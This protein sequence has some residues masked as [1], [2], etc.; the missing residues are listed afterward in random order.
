MS[1]RMTRRTFLKVTA[2]AGAGV[3]FAPAG[4]ARTYE[5]NERVNVAFVGAGGMGGGNLGEISRLQTAK[6]A[7]LANVVALCDVDRN[8]LAGAAKN[9]PAAKTYVDFRKMLSEMQK[10]IDAVMVSTPDHT[11]YPA[12]AMAIKLGMGVSTEKPLTHSIWEAR[13]LGL[14]A[15]KHKVATQ[16]DHEGHAGEGLRR[17][18]E[19]IKAGLIGAVREAHIFTDRPIWPQGIAKRPPTEPVPKHLEWDLWIGPAPYRDYHRH[20]HPFAWRGWWDFGTGALG[21]MG[22]HFFD[23][24]FWALDLGEALKI[25]DKHPIEIS[26]EHEGNSD[27]TYPNWSIVTLK[28]P[29]RGKLPPVTVKWYDGHKLPTPPKEF[30]EG[31][32]FPIN[33]SMFIGDKGPMLVYDTGGARLLPESRM[34]EEEVR[35][36]KPF[37]PRSPGHK[38]E[39]LLA[40]K[41]EG[42]ASSNFTDYGGPLAEVVLLGN[43]AIKAGKTVE[44]D[45]VNLKA[46]NAPELAPWIHRE[47][48]KGWE[49]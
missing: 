48:R 12:S 9:H 20:L 34:K 41:G 25:S 6:G 49:V 10:G 42:K 19:Y 45:S 36:L 1:H 33:G 32:K 27:E 7:L 18:V 15:R 11:H 46:K 5:A 22:C 24:A 30:G 31:R 28:F 21:D 14:L 35:N 37:L 26:A 17:G 43:L 13:Q 3:V 29:A 23:L 4:A 44:W 2:A 16:H 47:Y 39:W 38:K 40:V 8:R